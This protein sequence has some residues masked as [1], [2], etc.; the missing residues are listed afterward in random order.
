LNSLACSSINFDEF[1]NWWKSNERMQALDI[2]SN[3]TLKAAVDYFRRVDSDGTGKIGL[4]GALALYS[5][6][7]RRV[8]RIEFSDLV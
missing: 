4:A 2:T 7:W 3:P 1:F 8:S 5:S 6:N